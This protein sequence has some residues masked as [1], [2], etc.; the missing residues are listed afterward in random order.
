MTVTLYKQAHGKGCILQ[1]TNPI[2]AETP[3]CVDNEFAR[4]C[5]RSWQRLLLGREDGGDATYLVE[6]DLVDIMQYQNV[7]YGVLSVLTV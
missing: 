2:C 1:T 3:I 4:R 5:A 7:S 6:Q